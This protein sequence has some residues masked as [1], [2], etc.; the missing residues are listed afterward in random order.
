MNENQDMVKALK[1][2][3]LMCD[4]AHEQQAQANM[5]ARQK[6]IAKDIEEHWVE[7]ERTKIVE[8]DAKMRAKLEQ[9]YK[10]KQQNAKDISE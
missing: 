10:I 4:V 5:K 8:Y 6:Q 9:E 2:K 7:V 1:G 3:M